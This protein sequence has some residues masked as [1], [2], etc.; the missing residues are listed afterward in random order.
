VCAI[1]LGALAAAQDQRQVDVSVKVVEFQTNKGIETGLSAYFKQRIE[2]QPYGKVGRGLGV[3]QSA[4]FTFPTSTASGI[5]VFLDKLH[6]A[7]GD[8]E[9]V[10]QGLV[11]ENRASILSRPKVKVPVGAAAPTII[12]TTQDIPYESTVV[13]GATAVQTTA[14]RPTGVTLSVSAKQ[15]VDDD[16]NF[17]TANDTYI[18]LELKAEVNEEGPSIT[19]ALGDIAAGAN[20]AL[21][22]P[23]F[24]SRSITTTVWVRHGQVLVLGG[25]YRNSDSK[26]YNTPPWLP[27]AED[28]VNG[29]VQRIVP[30]GSPEIPLTAAIGNRKTSEDR[31]E[32]VFL[33]KAEIW[34]PSFTINDDLGLADNKKAPKKRL[35][36]TDVITGVLGEIA[37]MPHTIASGIAGE[38]KSS[39]VS[40]G[41]GKD[42]E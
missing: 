5:T 32:L 21:S 29:A 24:I 7:Y 37:D 28:L 25:L 30:F 4:D 26:N 36:P 35:S 11:D 40:T 8:F 38:K 39:D 20:N 27:Q 42:D 16:G 19:V 34:R 13:V 6:N 10:L 31:R 9:V 33:I 15:V 23:E 1:G 41:L 2:P 3:I 22:V 12:K 18:L 14:F 17:E